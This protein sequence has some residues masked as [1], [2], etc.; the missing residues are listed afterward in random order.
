LNTFK[1]TILEHKIPFYFLLSK[2]N[3]I[4]SYQNDPKA[5]SVDS[6]E[7]THLIKKSSDESTIKKWRTAGVAFI[8]SAAALLSTTSSSTGGV[9]RGAPA[10]LDGINSVG[11][12]MSEDP[13]SCLNYAANT[14]SVCGGWWAAGNQCLTCSNESVDLE[15][16]QVAGCGLTGSINGD[17][18]V[19]DTYGCLYSFPNYPVTVDGTTG[20]SWWTPGTPKATILDKVAPPAIGSWVAKVIR[21]AP[22]V[23]DGINSV[24]GLMSEGPTS[25]VNYDTNTLSVCGGWWAAGNQCRTCTGESVDLESNQ[26]AGCGLTGSISGGGGGVTD[27]YGCLNSFP[28]YPVTVDGTTGGSWWTPG[29]PKAK[30]LDKVAPS[31]IGSWVA[32]GSHQSMTLLTTSGTSGSTSKSNAFTATHSQSTSFSFGFSKIVNVNGKVTHVD[33]NGSTS[34]EM[35]T[36][37]YSVSNTV[38]KT[39]QGCQN[40][41]DKQFQWYLTYPDGST[42]ETQSYKCV[43]QSVVDTLSHY[44]IGLGQPQCPPANCGCFSCQCCSGGEGIP[45]DLLCYY[46]HE[47]DGNKCDWDT[48]S[49]FDL[50]HYYGLN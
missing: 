6:E 48:L 14:L 25:C 33:T 23:L 13:T 4:M 19:T 49:S 40:T 22:A 44:N 36:T 12:L 11:D 35:R 37:S 42:I 2:S 9:I 29:T 50:E 45:Q 21:G 28:N 32:L 15:S 8:I 5:P 47:E 46:N 16:K 7:R 17:G 20:G 3:I 24:G 26:V 31:A 10:V 1:V 34:T 18:D 39:T 38:S 27:T 41:E 30:I 43:P